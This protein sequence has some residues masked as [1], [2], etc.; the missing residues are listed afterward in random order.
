MSEAHQLSDAQLAF[1]E[2]LWERGEATVADVQREL[3]ARDR[4]LATTTVATVLGRLEKRGAVSRRAVGRQYLYRAAISRDAVRR[5]VLSRVTSGLFGGSVSALVGQLLESERV[6]AEELD[7]VRRL[8]ESHREGT[9]SDEHETSGGDAGVQPS[10]HAG[11]S[12]EED[13]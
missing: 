2:V 8:L 9:P 3:A 12:E 7:E 4:E 13:A 10:R 5:T 11:S 6:T 1:M